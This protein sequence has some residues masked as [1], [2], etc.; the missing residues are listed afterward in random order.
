MNEEMIKRVHP[1]SPCM[2][3]TYIHYIYIIYRWMKRWSR[4][5]IPCHPACLIRIYIIYIIYRWM[6]RWSRHPVSPSMFNAIRI[7]YIIYKQMK[8]LTRGCIP[9]HPPCLIYI[10][11]IDRWRAIGER[12]VPV[13]LSMFNTIYIIRI[14]HREMKR[15][16]RGGIPNHSLYIIL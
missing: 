1:V 2:F 14:I 9:C 16:A 3:N 7:I 4:E 10:Y 6:K 15:R 8:R 13:S 5:G 11:H 12:R